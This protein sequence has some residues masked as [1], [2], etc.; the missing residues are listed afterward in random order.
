MA[1]QSITP[2]KHKSAMAATVRRLKTERID[3]EVMTPHQIK[4]DDIN[5]YPG[6]GT[7]YRDGDR[8]AL[9]ES[10]LEN[11]IAL[12]RAYQQEESNILYL[13]LPD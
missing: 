8:R 9:P 4:V 13:E 11:F 1:S 12:A 10:G 2:D 3:Y 6:R 7:I 5:F